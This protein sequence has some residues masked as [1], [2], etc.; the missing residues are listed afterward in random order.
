MFSTSH[1]WAME[2]LYNRKWKQ[3]RRK[4]E[5]LQV[6]ISASS[7]KLSWRF[8]MKLI[9]E[10]QYI[11]THC[12]GMQNSKTHTCLSS[13]LITTSRLQPRLTE[14]E[15]V[16]K[17]ESACGLHRTVRWEMKMLLKAPT[18][19]K[20][21][22]DTRE[23][24]PAFITHL[25]AQGQFTMFVISWTPT[26]KESELYWEHLLLVWQKA[27]RSFASASTNSPLAV[28]NHLP[29][30]SSLRGALMVTTSHR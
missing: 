17:I 1:Y 21:L 11:C 18:E 20:H 9:Q 23:F 10:S 29:A 12:R 27:A 6:P 26:S 16:S 14:L 15:E 5:S 8:N 3:L 19:V 24:T 22:L 25:I 2:Y 30:P 13:V 28:S 4:R 7:F